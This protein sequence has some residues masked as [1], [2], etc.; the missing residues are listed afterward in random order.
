MRLI[1]FIEL[2]NFYVGTL[3]HSPAKQGLAVVVRD[4]LVVDAS[5]IAS[6]WGVRVGMSRKRAQVVCPGLVCHDFQAEAS[7]S[8]HERVWG[9]FC[10]LTPLIEP[11][12]FHCGYLDL[13]GCRL[14]EGSLEKTLAS[15]ADTIAHRF[16]ITMSLSAG[17]NKW[18]AWLTR[19]SNRWSAPDEENQLLQ[20]MPLSRMLIPDD[21]RDRL[22]R[23]GI[24]TIGALLDTPMTFLKNHLA[25]SDIDIQQLFWQ[26]RSDVKALFPAPSLDVKEDLSWF[27]P[28]SVGRV[29]L[30]VSERLHHEL[31]QCSRRTSLIKLT[32]KRRTDKITF[33]KKLREPTDSNVVFESFLRDSIQTTT[34]EI[35]SLR[36]IAEELSFAPK[37]QYD[38]WQR[39]I[40]F[41]KTLERTQGILQRRF[42][43]QI[44]HNGSDLVRAV[45]PRFAQLVYARKGIFL[46]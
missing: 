35:R 4:G 30:A 26:D 23:Y 22:H 7:K 6:R 13:T 44:L 28:E 38:L 39:T 25:M 33:E 36:L 27:D 1:V 46:P 21:L 32:V 19:G 34:R 40:T 12:D 8:L 45:P 18:I 2:K 11:T 31:R 14:I 43:D 5:E 42:G 16:E 37:P 17:S 10:D 9:M 15:L 20:Q 29:L 3:G 24:K 41:Q